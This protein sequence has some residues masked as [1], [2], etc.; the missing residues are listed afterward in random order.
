[1]CLCQH[2][3][4][5]NRVTM[6]GKESAFPIMAGLFVSIKQKDKREREDILNLC[7]DWEEDWVRHMCGRAELGLGDNETVLH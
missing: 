5:G 7:C 3:N 1:M 2:R 6:H 4:E